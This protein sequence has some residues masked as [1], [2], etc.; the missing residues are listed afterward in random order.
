MNDT[1][2]RF[3]SFFFFFVKIRMEKEGSE[4]VKEWSDRRMRKKLKPFTKN[5]REAGHAE[6]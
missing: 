5:N 1:N 4:K 3:V 6:K 2:L